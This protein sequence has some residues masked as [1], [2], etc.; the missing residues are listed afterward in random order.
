MTIAT[1]PTEVQ[2]A[3]GS[4]TF[5]LHRVRSNV[6]V[7]Y[8][9]DQTNAEASEP[10]DASLA[11]E[12]EEEEPLKLDRLGRPLNFGNYVNG[13]LRTVVAPA[14]P[15]LA[16]LLAD[17]EAPQ[18]EAVDNGMNCLFRARSNVDEAYYLPQTGSV[19]GQ[20][21]PT[22]LATKP[23]EE[24]A[25]A[26]DEAGGCG[27]F[28]LH[29]VRSN[30]DIL[31][32]HDQPEDEASKPATPAAAAARQAARQD[33]IEEAAQEAS[34]PFSLH[35][36]RSN[37]DILYYQDKPELVDS[38]SGTA[39]HA[40]EPAEEPE[41]QEESE[42]NAL[43]SL[44]LARTRSNLDVLYYHDQTNAEASEPADASLATEPEEE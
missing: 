30:V 2:E 35:R 24:P 22:T 40:G 4:G 42:D 11:T 23:A 29:R 12:P 6:D 32:Y 3:G 16:S 21:V 17:A 1:E 9:H 15:D 8:Y 38:E 20:P 26:Q 36:V 34:K 14:A 39:D 19:D 37:V 10:A 13:R 43:N 5:S 41:P 7:L 33:A 31:Y 25:P 27:T 28:S 18:D 44:C